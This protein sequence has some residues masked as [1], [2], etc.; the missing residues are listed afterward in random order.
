MEVPETRMD[1]AMPEIQNDKSDA[2]QFA[3]W[4]R[5]LYRESATECIQ[6]LDGRGRHDELL[7]NIHAAFGPDCVVQITG[8]RVRV[9][10]ESVTGWFE[11]SDPCA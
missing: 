5:V 3:G 10:H 2:P 1:A 9:V 6:W 11:L 8:G 4:L 7:E